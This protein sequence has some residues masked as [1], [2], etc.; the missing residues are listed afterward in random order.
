MFLALCTFSK[1]DVLPSS[2]TIS[3]YFCYI[4]CR[5]YTMHFYISHNSLMKIRHFLLYRKFGKQIPP[6][7]SSLLMVCLKKILISNFLN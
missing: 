3:I 7:L 5:K 1:S 6:L 4:L 2:R